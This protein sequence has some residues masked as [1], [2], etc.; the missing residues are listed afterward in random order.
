FIRLK[1]KSLDKSTRYVVCCD[2]GR[3]SSAAA[4]IL[5][6]RGFDA[7]VLKGGLTMADPEG[8]RRKS[9]ESAD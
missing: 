3:R 7:H 8:E 2:T 5:S 9:A 1:L 4:Y 6:E